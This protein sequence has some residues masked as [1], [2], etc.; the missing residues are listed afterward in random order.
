MGLNQEGE[1]KKKKEKKK[2]VKRGIIEKL[3]FPLCQ[4]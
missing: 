4:M 1:G 2:K 3:E